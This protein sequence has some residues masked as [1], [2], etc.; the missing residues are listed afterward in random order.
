ML[1]QYKL[2]VYIF[3]RNDIVCNAYIACRGLIHV[4]TITIIP[5]AHTLN[6]QWM[7]MHNH[8]QIERH[9]AR[10]V[11][12]IINTQKKTSQ[13]VYGKLHSQIDYEFNSKFYSFF[14]KFKQFYYF[15]IECCGS[16][17]VKPH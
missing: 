8:F 7:I 14:R 10:H 3:D 16:K 4:T 13:V 5:Y 17:E 15:F 6:I 1:V 9:S 12:C 11:H 2:S